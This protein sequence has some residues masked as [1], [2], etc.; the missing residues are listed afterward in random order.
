[1]YCIIHSFKNGCVSNIIILLTTFLFNWTKKLF[2]VF[3]Y[4]IIVYFFILPEKFIIYFFFTCIIYEFILW[5]Y[6]L[7]PQ[8]VNINTETL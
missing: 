3:Y 7:F 8:I 1:M 6:W 5:I 4:D 2:I